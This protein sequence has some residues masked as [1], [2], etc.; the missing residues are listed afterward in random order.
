MPQHR[1]LPPPERAARSRL[2]RLL[3][4]P[5]P[6]LRASLVQMR[7]RC[8]KPGCHCAQGQ[9]HPS[10]YVATRVGRGRKMIYVP[11][12]L[13]GQV[14]RWVGDARQSDLDLDVLSQ[15]ALGRLLAQKHHKQAPL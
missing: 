8:G 6:L 15:S 14:R 1:N 7:R 3:S 10:L 4:Q 2:V 12:D 9:P 13:E 5:R 11:K